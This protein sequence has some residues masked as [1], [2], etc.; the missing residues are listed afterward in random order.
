MV[1]WWMYTY[2]QVVQDYCEAVEDSRQCIAMY[3]K[4]AMHCELCSATWPWPGKY[5]DAMGGYMRDSNPTPVKE[6]V[7][8]GWSTGD[9]P[10]RP[11]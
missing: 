6:A 9:H 8:T 4:V 1:I 10:N 3:Y 5:L 2:V 7:D 11:D